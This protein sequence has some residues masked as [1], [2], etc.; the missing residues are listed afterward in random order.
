MSWSLLLF[1]RLAC[2]SLARRA[3]GWLVSPAEVAG[4]TPARPPYNS[5]MN[6]P[7][8]PPNSFGPSPF[9]PKPPRKLKPVNPRPAAGKDYVVEAELLC[10]TVSTRVLDEHIERLR[11]QLRVAETIRAERKVVEDKFLKMTTAEL[12]AF[13]T[14][15]VPGPELAVAQMVLHTRKPK[16]PAAR[17]TM[18]PKPPRRPPPFRPPPR[19]P[20]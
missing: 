11:V 3:K 2:P 9:P 15:G 10:R 12:E 20:S 17:K 16:A 7:P 4:E 8:R 13:V 1:G 14:A 5:S 18:P 19:R 6:R